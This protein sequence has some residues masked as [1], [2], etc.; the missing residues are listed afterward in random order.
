MKFCYLGPQAISR[1]D[2]RCFITPMCTRNRTIGISPLEGGLFVNLLTFA[3]L[4]A[5]CAHRM[6]AFGVVMRSVPTE[7]HFRRVTGREARR[8]E[9]SPD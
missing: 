7:S 6:L 9:A 8:G 5:F 2:F 3:H 4:Q 1:S